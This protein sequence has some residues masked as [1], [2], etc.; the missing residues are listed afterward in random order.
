M[1]LEQPQQPGKDS[2]PI[3]NFDDCDDW[4]ASYL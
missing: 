4:K 2:H 3:R 1:G